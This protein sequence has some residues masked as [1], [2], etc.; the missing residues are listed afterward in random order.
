MIFEQLWCN[1]RQYYGGKGV[2]MLNVIE[3]IWSIMQKSLKENQVPMETTAWYCLGSNLL[4]GLHI[5]A[6]EVKKSFIIL[7][8]CTKKVKSHTTKKLVCFGLSLTS[9]SYLIKV[10]LGNKNFLHPASDSLHDQAVNTHKHTHT[11]TQ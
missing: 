11:H 1:K 3:E 7:K 6:L 9:V 2:E 10:V 8:M 5:S 4:Q